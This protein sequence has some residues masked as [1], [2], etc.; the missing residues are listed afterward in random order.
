METPA[1][2][3][4]INRRQFVQQTSWTAAA[5]AAPA[6]MRA[7]RG[8]DAPSNKIIL[9]VMGTNGRGSALASEFARLDGCEI[10]TICDVDSRAIAKGI[11]QVES[12]TGTAPSAQTDIRKV[13]EDKAIDA[14]VIA[15]PD[16]WHAPATIMACGQGKHVYVEKPAC[17]NPLEGMWMIEAARKNNRVVQMGS[18]RRSS[19]GVADAIA[20]VHRGDI[21]RVLFSRGW[22]NSTRP[23]IGHGKKATA[24]EW[25]DYGLWQGPAPRQ[26]F[27]DNTIH[28]NWHWFWD[29]GTGELGNNGIHAL[30]LCRWGLQADYPE[31]VICGGGK[32]WFDDDQQTPDTQ[33]ATFHFSDNRVANWEH[34]TWHR[35]GFEGQ[36]WGVTF[37]GDNG[38]LV[39][40]SSNF[41]VFDMQGKQL[42]EV[43]ITRGEME[44]LSNFLASI[45]GDETPNAEI[46]EGVK[47]TM[48]CNLGNIAY[49][50]QSTVHFDTA[51][52]QIVDNPEA[53][54]LWRR[55]YAEGWEPQV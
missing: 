47:S 4:A 55:D 34:R 29:W 39:L 33:I 9:A 46:E 21:G 20:R 40:G 54:A 48:L 51:K 30:D 42:E 52:R 5:L 17:H 35:R 32:L 10:A 38:S 28:Y 36:T 24:P 26:D 6:V 19:P 8:A 31:R 1:M 27:R 3:S 16:H 25:L 41:Q 22:I 18:Q 49:R 44:H 45:R 14:I 2:A 53:V 15:A 23:N 50:T 13:L 11:K 12:H 43:A 37:Y 7:A